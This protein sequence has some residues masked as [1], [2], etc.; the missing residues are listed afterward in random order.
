MV[1]R[2]KVVA[3]QRARQLRMKAKRKRKAALPP[4]P[5]SS[6]NALSPPAHWTG[7]R[8]VVL[9]VDD[10][11]AALINAKKIL[12]HKMY[13][14]LLAE[15]GRE[16]WTLLQDEKPDLILSD[17]DMPALDGFGLLKLVREDLRLSDMPF[18]LMT[19]NMAAHAKAF[20]QKGFD[21]LLPKPYNP[22]D[23]VEQIRFLLKE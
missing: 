7:K 3:E 19:S 20:E 23:L 8:P 14:V 16:A 18:I 21:S 17:I 22:E 4:A 6:E 1:R 10:S 13:R 9:V 5:L 2:G 12:E 15:N 11:K